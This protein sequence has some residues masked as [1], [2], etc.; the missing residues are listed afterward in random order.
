[1]IIQ[2]IFGKNIDNCCYE[3]ADIISFD[4]FDTLVFRDVFFP[5]TVFQFIDTDKN[6]SSKRKI[7]EKKARKSRRGE[8]TLNDIYYYLPE[9]DMNREIEAEFTHVYAN[10]EMLDFYNKM[11]AKNKELIIISD[12]YLGENVIKSMLES[13]GYDLTDVEL[14]ISSKYGET[15]KNGDLFERVIKEKN[16]QKEKIIH[17]GDNW[18]VDYYIPKM[19]GL[20]AFLYKP[21]K[22]FW[23]KNIKV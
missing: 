21:R 6:F 7:A 19:K 5:E 22:N 20:Q 4:V 13:S 15:K 8:V 10:V 1:M 2:Y 23:T 11:K 16:I 18:L 12:M 17:L 9:F 14:Y 3:K